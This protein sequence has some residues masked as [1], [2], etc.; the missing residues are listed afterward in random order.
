MLGFL[1][2]IDARGEHG[3][4][5]DINPLHAVCAMVTLCEACSVCELFVLSNAC[6]GARARFRLV[7]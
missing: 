7:N 6:R 2:S 4:V 5:G 3:A 1:H